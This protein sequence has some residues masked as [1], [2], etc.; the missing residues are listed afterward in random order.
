MKSRLLSNL[1]RLL[2]HIFK[3][4]LLLAI[5]PDQILRYPNTIFKVALLP[6]DFVSLWAVYKFIYYRSWFGIASWSST[7]SILEFWLQIKLVC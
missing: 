2:H 6:N 5:L 4:F 1:K 7:M 3:L